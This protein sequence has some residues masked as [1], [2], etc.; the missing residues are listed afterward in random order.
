METAK[1]ATGSTFPKKVVE[2]VMFC[3]KIPEFPEKRIFE[4]GFEWHPA[5]IF[6]EMYVQK[7][8]SVNLG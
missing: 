5:L 6:P 2:F 7:N 1:V 4:C 3:F 8:I